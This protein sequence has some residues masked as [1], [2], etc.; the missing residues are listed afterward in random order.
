MPDYFWEWYG[1]KG[2]NEILNKEI[3]FENKAFL[4]GCC[5]EYLTEKGQKITNLKEYN[6]LDEIVAYLK[7][8]VVWTK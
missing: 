1:R 7:L 5:I 8:G 3:C 2:Y 6:N 4:V